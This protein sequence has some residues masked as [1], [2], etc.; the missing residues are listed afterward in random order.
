MIFQYAIPIL[1]VTVAYMGILRKLKHRMVRATKS[2]QLD[3]KKRRDKHR[4]RKT[5]ILLFSVAIIFGISWLPLNILNIV[6]DMFQ[7]EIEE[8]KF[9]IYFA[10]CHMIGM[11]SA[12]SNPLLYGW[13]NENF[14]KEFVDIFN[15]C[16]P[17]HGGRR[18]LT[19]VTDGTSR[20]AVGDQNRNIARL[21]TIDVECGGGIS[22]DVEGGAEQLNHKAVNF[23]ATI[24]G[25]GE[26][27]SSSSN[28]ENNNSP[29]NSLITAVI[30][31]T[32]TGA[33]PS[34]HAFMNSNSMKKVVL[35]V[36]SIVT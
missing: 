9:R 1:I 23:K 21:I 27:S 2:T 15:T 4:I 30:T 17:S 32:T 35:D 12:C 7:L 6:V 20:S 33:T 31:T 19:G 16:S 10:I 14:R 28:N 22:G 24:N 25:M 26:S 8:S 11:S 18:S 29:T 5:N 36:Q 34:H 3:E 13:L